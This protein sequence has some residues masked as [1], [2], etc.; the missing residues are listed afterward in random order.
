MEF[1]IGE[2]TEIY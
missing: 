1:F 2:F